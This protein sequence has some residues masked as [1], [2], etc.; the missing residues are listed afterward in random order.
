PSIAEGVV[1]AF[2]L[3][4][5]GLVIFHAVVPARAFSACTGLGGTCAIPALQ[6]APR[7]AAAIKNDSARV[8]YL[9]LINFK[10]S[11][12]IPFRVE[13]IGAFEGIV[14]ASFTLFF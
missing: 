8:K 9:V 1:C 2:T 11:I 13:F 3:V 12:P 4:T 10:L 14:I 5:A 7:M 6:A